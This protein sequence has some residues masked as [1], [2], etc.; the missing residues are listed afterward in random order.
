[1]GRARNNLSSVALWIISLSLGNVHASVSVPEIWTEAIA[2]GD[3]IVA[4]PDQ[5][6]DLGLMPSVA[7]GFVGAT[8]GIDALYMAGL[9]VNEVE[10]IEAGC[11]Q[12]PCLG[13]N[14]SKLNFERIAKLLNPQGRYELSGL[15]QRLDE[16]VQAN[17]SRLDIVEHGYG[18]RR[19]RLPYPHAISMEIMS[20]TSSSSDP[21]TSAVA[22]DMANAMVYR[23]TEL[24]NVVASQTWFT[25]RSN[26]SLLAMEVSVNNSLSSSE[27]EVKLHY[28][29]IRGLPEDVVFGDEMD[30]MSLGISN[31]STCK[32]GGLT[33]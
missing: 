17:N 5:D 4:F 29:F 22:L 9:Y 27:S 1:M 11:L 16:I 2:R 12:V 3:M 8:I 7:N 13:N 25:H 30:G 28:D 19:A 26:R 20:S 31:Q 24:N 23:R 21:S 6:F 10:W 32:Q 15:C 14:E 33:T 18:S